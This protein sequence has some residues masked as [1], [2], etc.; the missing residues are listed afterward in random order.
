VL[1]LLLYEIKDLSLND[2]VFKQKKDEGR[3]SA[4]IKSINLNSV[5]MNNSDVL[6]EFNSNTQEY[7]Q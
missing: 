6:I 3:L 2:L 7:C 5:D 1:S 4:V